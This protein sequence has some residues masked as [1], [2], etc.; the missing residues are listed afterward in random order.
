VFY[1]LTP[2]SFYTCT[3]GDKIWVSPRGCTKNY[4]KV[5]GKSKPSGSGQNKKKP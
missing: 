4:K 2:G 5:S 1:K 3:C